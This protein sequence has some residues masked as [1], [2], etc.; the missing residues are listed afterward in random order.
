MRIFM[1]ICALVA[2]ISNRATANI[3][4]RI[5][6]IGDSWTEGIGVATRCYPRAQLMST[7]QLSATG[8]TGCQDLPAQIIAALPPGIVTSYQNLGLGGGLTYDALMNAVPLID[9]SVTAVVV[10][11]GLNDEPVLI[12]QYGSLTAT[13][14]SAYNPQG[15]AE[16]PTAVAGYYLQMVMAIKKAAPEADLYLVE[17]FDCSNNPVTTGDVCFGNPN[18]PTINAWWLSMIGQ[19]GNA[20][21]NIINLGSFPT[22]TTLPPASD[23]NPAGTCLTP[24]VGDCGGHPNA[25][26]YAA[27]ASIIAAGMV[28]Q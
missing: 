28:T 1:M 8:L 16:T 9:P 4:S 7:S 24:F 5:A 14:S 11:I 15:F 3:P 12:T 27:I 22:P 19:Y 18:A 23:F 26:G 25:A 10:M 6:F 20:A 13:T 21:R 17:P 2:F